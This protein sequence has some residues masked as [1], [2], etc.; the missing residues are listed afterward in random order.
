MGLYNV[1]AVP[2]RWSLVN[3]LATFQHYCWTPTVFQVFYG[4]INEIA[5][6]AY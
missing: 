2:R 3:Y 1:L 6:F 4:T 5:R